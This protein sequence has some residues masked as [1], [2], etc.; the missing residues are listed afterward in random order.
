MNKENKNEKV[1]ALYGAVA[2]FVM[3]N[4][5]LKKITVADITNR[6]GIGK[7]TAYEYF[8][9]KDDIIIEAI[10]Y[11]EQ[12]ALFETKEELEKIE[13]F[14]EKIMYLFT[15]MEKERVEKECFLKC[16]H[17]AIGDGEIA[18]KIRK[19]LSDKDVEMTPLYV[20]DYLRQCGIKEGMISNKYPYEYLIA[21]LSSRL[22][23]FL[24]SCGYKGNQII[25]NH[26]ELK[27]QLY[28]GIIRE[29]RE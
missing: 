13:T 29:L 11:F 27:E 7:G 8:K 10:L 5:D 21:T 26:D 2:E 28:E 20:V 23:I 16:V 9:S 3:E 12:K 17:I 19:R 25:M 24:V 22:G 14:R 18:D 15:L 1:L 4:A 6:A